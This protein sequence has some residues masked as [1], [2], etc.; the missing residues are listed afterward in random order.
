MSLYSYV[1]DSP[2]ESSERP[3]YALQATDLALEHVG[4]Q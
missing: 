3:C 1:Q 2:L 4:S